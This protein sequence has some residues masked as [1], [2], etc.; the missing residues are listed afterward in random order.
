[1]LE[2]HTQ[3]RWKTYLDAEQDRIYAVSVSAL[4]N[5]WSNFERLSSSMQSMN[6]LMEYFSSVSLQPLTNAID[7]LNCSRSSKHTLK[8]SSNK[9]NTRA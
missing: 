4:E 7:F 6:F 8:F 3:K 5:V 1:M 9:S 2:P